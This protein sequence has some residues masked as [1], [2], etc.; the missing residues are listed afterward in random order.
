[1]RQVRFGGVRK[2]IDLV[3]CDECHIYGNEEK[4]QN[5]DRRKTVERWFQDAI[6]EALLK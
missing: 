2:V 1:M 3:G 6:R 4:C 5:S